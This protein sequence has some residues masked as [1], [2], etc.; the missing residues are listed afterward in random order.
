LTSPPPVIPREHREKDS[1]STCS[2]KYRLVGGN[3][4][5][6][7][8]PHHRDHHRGF[9]FFKLQNLRERFDQART[10]VYN[11][12]LVFTASDKLMGRENQ[13]MMTIKHDGFAARTHDPQKGMCSRYRF[14]LAQQEN[15]LRE[16]CPREIQEIPDHG[17]YENL[18]KALAFYGIIPEDVPSPFNLNQHMKIAA[19]QAKWNI[20]RCAPRKATTWISAPRWICSSRLAPAR[21]SSPAA[22]Q[23]TY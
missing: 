16:Y 19:S 14:K 1:R 20:P 5:W 8:Y 2:A 13:H 9:C 18:S 7:S 6:P 3:E 22:S 12:T 11:M 4:P 10:K 21:T 17:C 15:S 23:W